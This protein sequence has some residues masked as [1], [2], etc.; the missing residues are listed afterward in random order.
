MIKK[1]NEIN[2]KYNLMNNTVA[3]M[4]YMQNLKALASAVSAEMQKQ[5]LNTYE[6]ADRARKKGY[7]I[8]HGTVWN[9]INCNVKE[10]KDKSIV[11]IAH[12]LDLP[13]QTLFA[14]VRGKKDGAEAAVSERFIRL[15]EHYS[16]LQEPERQQIEP[17][18]AA[19]EISISRFL[20]LAKSI[21]KSVGGKNIVLEKY[22]DR[23]KDD[24]I[25][26]V[27]IKK[28]SQRKAS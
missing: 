18:I 28:P 1:V 27:K 17:F 10:V 23:E 19:L 14:I 4:R 16:N 5:N 24:D 11:A 22:L 9:V 12:G 6:V 13:E 25:N 7:K 20:P 26:T 8:V 2:K 15:A 3:I 21:T